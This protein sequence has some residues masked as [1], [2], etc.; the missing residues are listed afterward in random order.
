M[1]CSLIVDVKGRS[2]TLGEAVPSNSTDRAPGPDYCALPWQ[3]A[4]MCLV[5]TMVDVG[6]IR[7]A[8]REAETT[9]AE[10]EAPVAEVTVA[11]ADTAA[12][13]GLVCR[14]WNDADDTG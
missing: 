8:M 3:C 7:D 12:G 10:I 5:S 14:G 1:P 9:G 4:K 2:V 6:R 13:G 11:P